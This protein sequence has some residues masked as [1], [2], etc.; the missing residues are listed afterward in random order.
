MDSELAQRSRWRNIFQSISILLLMAVLLGG[1]GWLLGGMTGLLWIGVIGMTLFVFTPKV[2]PRVVL[3]MYKASPI[4]ENELP[5]LC[6]LVGS[7]SEKAGLR[8][9]P[10]MYYIPSRVMNAF[11]VGTK[12]DAAIGL[13]D[14][15]LRSMSKR[16]IAGILAHELNHIRHN[17]LWMIPR[18]GSGGEGGIE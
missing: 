7:L 8:H 17:D 13:S 3:S 16:E 5:G 6:Q 2:T 1:I 10:G 9:V 11:S 14:G 18:A 4:H 15:L 12:N